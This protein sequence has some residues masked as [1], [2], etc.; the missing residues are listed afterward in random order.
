MK[1]IV[2]I[3][4]LATAVS[5]LAC[6]PSAEELEKEKKRIADSTRVADSTKAA[7]EAA[8]AQRIADSTNAA[9]EMKRIADSTRV[10][11]SLAALKPKGGSKP[12]PKPKPTEVK[13]VD[14][15]NKV[16]NKK[17]GAK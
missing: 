9:N 3:I 13:P 16:G 2:S 10:A 6:G 11:D 15:S 1:K 17:Q 7:A 4:T 12:T 8:E 14:G 5:F